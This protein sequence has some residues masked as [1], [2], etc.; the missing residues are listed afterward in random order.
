[1]HSPSIHHPSI[2]FNSIQYNLILPIHLAIQ[3]TIMTK[4]VIVKNIPCCTLTHNL[5][6]T[7]GE[8]SKW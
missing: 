3:L 5:E 7:A 1:M 2:Q 8:V 6:R 4:S